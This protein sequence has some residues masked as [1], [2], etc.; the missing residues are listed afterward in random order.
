MLVELN[1]Y[2]RKSPHVNYS[3][4]ILVPRQNRK[5]DVLRFVDQNRIWYWFST[6]VVVRISDGLVVVDQSWSLGVVEIAKS[7]SIFFIHTVRG[8]DVIDEQRASKSINI[9]TTNVSMVPVSSRLRNCELVDKNSTRRDRA[10][11]HHGRPICVGCVDL[12]KTVEMNGSALIHKV[13]RQRDYDGVTNIDSNG[14]IWPLPIDADE[15]P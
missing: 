1:I 15:W 4:E 10:L 9:L 6:I 8:I 11:G 12:M 3:E 5:S 14:R 13:I 7:Q 2:R